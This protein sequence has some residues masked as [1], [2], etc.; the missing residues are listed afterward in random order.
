[1]WPRRSHTISPLPKLIY[2]TKK[3]Q[4]TK[5]KQDDF[6]EIK[7]IVDRDTSLTYLDFDE[8]FKIHTHASAFQLIAFIIQKFK[9]IVFTAKTV[10]EREILITIETLK[11][12]RTILLGQRLII[13]T[14][15]KNLTCKFLI[16]T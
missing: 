9:Y 10:T 4:W 14:D 2:I 13:Y 6:D 8:T 15:H 11:E 12:F 16:P 5:V 7:R 3:L 1:M